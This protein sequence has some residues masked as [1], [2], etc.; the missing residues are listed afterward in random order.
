MSLCFFVMPCACTVYSITLTKMLNLI[1]KQPSN[2]SIIKWSC[3]KNKTYE[4][5]Y[6]QGKMLSEKNKTFFPTVSRVLLSKIPF[7][8]YSLIQINRV[9]QAPVLTHWTLNLWGGYCYNHIKNPSANAR[10][11]GDVGSTPG[12]GSSPGEGSGTPLQYSC[13]ENSMDRKAWSMGSQKVEHNWATEQARS[14]AHVHAGTDEV[15]EAQTSYLRSPCL[16][17]FVSSKLLFF[18]KE[19][20]KKEFLKIKSLLQPKLL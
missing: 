3:D 2:G 5:K 20:R 14:H 9:G 12:S 17:F 6:L 4:Y 1:I 11:A 15:T 7:L 8:F 13:L 10:D 16:L 18:L 19:E